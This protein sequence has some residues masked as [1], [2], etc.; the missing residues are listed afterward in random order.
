[1]TP[2][3]QKR[4]AGRPALPESERLIVVPVRLY[5]AQR[6]K[7]RAMPDGLARLRAWIERQ[8]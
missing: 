5:P 3:T 4:K 6:D 8:R 1:M 2:D 7:L